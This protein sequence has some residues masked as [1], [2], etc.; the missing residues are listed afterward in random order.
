MRLSIFN[1]LAFG[2]LFVGLMACGG[3]SGTKIIDGPPGSGGSDAGPGACNVLTQMGCNTGEKCTWVEDT[4]TLGHVGCAPDGTVDVGGA[5]MYGQPGATGYDQCKAGLACVHGTCKTI[6]DQNGGAPMC[7]AMHACQVYSGLFGAVG[8]EAAG[9][10]DPLCNPLDD[11]DFDGSGTRLTKTGSACG[12][13]DGCYGDFSASTTPTHFSCA[14]VPSTSTSL[15]QG[16]PCNTTNMCADQQSGNPYLN[17]C[18][19]GYLPLITND[20]TGKNTFTCRA[21]CKPADCSSDKGCGTGNVDFVGASPHRCN[22][23]DAA[24]TF[25]TGTAAESCIYGWFFEVDQQGKFHTSPYDNNVGL[26]LSHA[27]FHLADST[28]MNASTTSWPACSSMVA[29][30][31]GSNCYGAYMGSA[32]DLSGCYAVDFGC[33]STTTGGVMFQKQGNHHVIPRPRLPYHLLN[34]L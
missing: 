25:Q 5:C 8:M 21:Y 31:S 26:C 16:S 9:V 22:N 3:K 14:G 29:S 13:A 20:T 34:Q 28:G 11:N 7:D 23:T 17:G 27:D 18:A 12:S 19:Q 10:C 6:C 33:V 4:M 30:G 24:G 15:F 32:A 1:K 2:A